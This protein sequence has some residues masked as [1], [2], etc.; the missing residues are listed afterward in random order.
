M[1][2]SFQIMLMAAMVM[3]ALTAYTITAFA[4][5]K[6]IGVRTGGSSDNGDGKPLKVEFTPVK[7]VFKTGEAIR[8]KVK[9]SETFYLY[10]FSVDE[11]HNK[12]YMILPNKKQQYIKYKAG[13]TY[14]VPEKYIEFYSD[15]PGREK[16]IMLASTKK[17][18]VKFDRYAT[19]GNILS[20]NFDTVVQ[21]TKALGIRS[22]EAKA[23]HVTKELSLIITGDG[24][25][26]GVVPPSDAGSDTAAAPFVSTN[27]SSYRVG[28]SIRI[29]F[30][31]DKPGYV[32]LYINEPGGR[33]S[34]L[35]TKKVSGSDFYRM[36]AMASRPGGAHQIL[37]VYDDN[38]T[39]DKNRIYTLSSKNMLKDIRLVPDT[40]G[41]YAVYHFTIQ[42]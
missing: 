33:Q 3:L 8:F 4:D 29:T 16:I 40:P 15:S 5:V 37:A 39:P 41:A 17:M 11:R 35:T 13:K 23:K 28:D 42:E 22:R 24:Q 1:K 19:A 38:A 25:H 10:L 18:D 32:H 14:T 36:N 12:G 30:G 7:Q 31:A 21:E 27:K 9:G 6:A 20:A 26:A 2:K 34:F